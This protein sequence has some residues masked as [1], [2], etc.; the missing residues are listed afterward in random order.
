M[1]DGEVPEVSTEVYGDGSPTQ[2]KVGQGMGAASGRRGGP[3][4]IELQHFFDS[5]DKIFLHNNNL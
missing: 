4:P 2:A 3:F 1:P 5:S